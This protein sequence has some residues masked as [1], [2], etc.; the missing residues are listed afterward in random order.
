MQVLNELLRAHPTYAYLYPVLVLA[1]VAMVVLV[2]DMFLAESRK[3]ML[4]LLAIAAMAY[5][6]VFM[7]APTTY[8]YSLVSSLAKQMLRFDPFARIFNLIFLVS[9]IVIVLL[10]IRY[11]PLKLYIG[12]YYVLL[13]IATTAFVTLA[14]ASNL[15]M[16]YLSIE[17][18]G[19]C[20]YILA[21]YFKGDP[22]SQEGALKYLLLGSVASAFL[23]Y[24]MSILYG[25]T[26]SLGLPQVAAALTT[27]SGA[28]HTATYI[29]FIFLLAGF[30]FK[31]AL[32]PFHMWC[33]D[34]Y[35]GSPTP[36]TAFF[37][38]A[39]KAAGI[40]VLLRVCL[41][42]FHG[43][44]VPWILAL[45]ILSA[46]TMS[47][48]NVVALWQTNIKRLL[49]YSSIAHV[50]YVL[51]GLV[52]A[53]SAGLGTTLGDQG[54]LSV[55][56][57]LIAYLFMN[58]G[59]FAVVIVVSNAI[60]SD[61]IEH[62]AGLGRRNPYMAVAL[63]VFFLSLAGIPPTVGFIGKFF[64]FKAAIETHFYMLSFFLLVNSVTSVYY[65]W[66][67]VRTMFID[68]PADAT[69]VRTAPA[70]WATTTAMLLAV[71]VLGIFFGQLYHLVQNANLII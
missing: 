38:V 40:A 2:F 50:G 29:A 67:V 44:P 4:G 55:I 69:P 32:V 8:D 42:V 52:V 11:K 70:L 60:G 13:L 63:T 53:G 66:N 7:L 46:V 51:I 1:G 24:G 26:G 64:L 43:T 21:A 49:A 54:L 30:G 17:T 3:H 47:V 31:I 71:I 58:L 37:S 62:Y 20:S 14:A 18:V 22:K 65:Y 28:H 33:P 68:E 61:R 57:Y 15:L 48:A 35:E 9:G 27:A 34:A 59:A 56:I 45:E 16:I 23:V 41:T 39:P 12:E 19:V 10:T 5:V 6:A 25:L 36:V